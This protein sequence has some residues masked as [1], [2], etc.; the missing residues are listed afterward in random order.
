VA[1]AITAAHVNLGITAALRAF[2]FAVTT[3]GTGHLAGIT[4]GAIVLGSD[5]PLTVAV[6]ALHK[7][8]IDGLA[9][10][11]AIHQN[12]RHQDRDYYF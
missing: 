12:Q 4:V 11:Y 7:G 10:Y 6:G 1:A 2:L 8:L 9:V 3:I 5:L